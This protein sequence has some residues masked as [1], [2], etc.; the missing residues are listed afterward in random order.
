VVDIWVGKKADL[1]SGGLGV[2]PEQT[3]AVL[4]RGPVLLKVQE[5]I[6]KIVQQ[7][8]KFSSK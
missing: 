6:Q 3:Y 5:K 2:N 4:V 7:D 1:G 8:R